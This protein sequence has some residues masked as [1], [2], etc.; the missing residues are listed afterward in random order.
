MLKNIYICQSMSKWCLK[1]RPNNYFQ[2]CVLWQVKS[3]ERFINDVIQNFLW[4]YVTNLIFGAI[5]VKTWTGRQLGRVMSE[6]KWWVTSD[7]VRQ[8]RPTMSD[9]H[10]DNCNFIAHISFISTRKLWYWSVYD[11][12]ILHLFFKPQKTATYL[13]LGWL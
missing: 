12:Q 2:K 8:V 10:W 6:V 7:H 4:H 9:E 11:I 13:K 1:V 5:T 3:D